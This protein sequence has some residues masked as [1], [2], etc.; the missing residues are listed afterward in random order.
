M[1]FRRTAGLA[2]EGTRS[3]RDAVARRFVPFILSGIEQ[4]GGTLA[5]RI[6]STHFQ[7][8]EPDNTVPPMRLR[9]VVFFWFSPWAESSLHGG[10]LGG[11]GIYE[12]VR[13][14]DLEPYWS[15]Q[16]FLGPRRFH[17]FLPGANRPTFS[18]SA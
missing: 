4:L 3:I 11:A 1:A 5:N 15:L 8:S 16:N 10:G 9:S 18:Y 12:V 17:T 6:T 14:S 2:A 13:R 7:R